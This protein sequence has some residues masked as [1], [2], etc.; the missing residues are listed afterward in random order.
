MS[1]Y[2]LKNGDRLGPYSEEELRRLIASGESSPSELVCPQGSRDWKP[3]AQFPALFEPATR[4]HAHVAARDELRSGPHLPRSNTAAG[5][6]HDTA[7]STSHPHPGDITGPFAP[8]ARPPG[9]GWI[10]GHWRGQLSLAAS[11]WLNYVLLGLV[12]NLAFMGMD[13]QSEHWTGYLA[14]V[15]FGIYG[16]LVIVALAVW[17]WQ[18]VGVWRAARRYVRA[19][20]HS[21]WAHLARV[22]V[23]LGTLASLGE[24]WS[25]DLVGRVKASTEI[26]LGLDGMSEFS[27]RVDETP[28]RAVIDGHIAF[29]VTDELKHLLRANPAIDTVVLNSPGGR[30]ME[31]RALHRIIANAGL[32]TT[33]EEGCYSACTLAFIAGKMRTAGDGLLGFH[34]PY[35]DFDILPGELEQWADR[36]KQYLLRAGVSPRFVERAYATGHD[37]L[38]F[39]TQQELRAAGVITEPVN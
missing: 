12:V 7:E 11:Y 4:S 31:G 34:H 3:A 38:W 27:V 32:N 5:G 37:Q 2:R 22:V 21:G 8:D 35:A 23:V 33:T 20:F 13:A 10:R 39:P 25:A 29:G 17:V 19:R 1:W 36:D 30:T 15:L 16:L 18:I 24:L 26:A 28:N 6:T 14:R 9:T